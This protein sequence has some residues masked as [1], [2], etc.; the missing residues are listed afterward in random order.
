MTHGRAVVILQGDTVP[1]HST[2]RKHF[3]NLKG[4]VPRSGMIF[5]CLPPERALTTAAW[6]ATSSDDIG[7]YDHYLF[8]VAHTSIF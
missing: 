2:L 5:R 8:N 6:A 7:F 4:H 1:F 3:A